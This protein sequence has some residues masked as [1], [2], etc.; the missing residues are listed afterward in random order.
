MYNTASYA[1]SQVS[2]N[3]LSLKPKNMLS[4]SDAYDES[5]TVI[6]C[7]LNPFFAA[8]TRFE[9]HH[10]T[11]IEYRLYKSINEPLLHVLI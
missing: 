4:T 8:T 10:I 11:I 1:A 5:D 3:P 6:V 7:L 9:V 2:H